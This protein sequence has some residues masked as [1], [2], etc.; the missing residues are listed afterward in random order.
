MY[1]LPCYSHMNFLSP[2]MCTTSQSSCQ[3]LPITNDSSRPLLYEAVAWRAWS[4]VAWSP[5]MMP[6]AITC[7]PKIHSPNKRCSPKSLKMTNSPVFIFIKKIVV[8]AQSSRQSIVW[9]P[10]AKNGDI[11]RLAIYGMELLPFSSMCWSPP[12]CCSPKCP[13]KTTHNSYKS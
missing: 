8:I 1:L 7:S 9:W 3:H 10:I 2:C 11:Y 4:H 12:L 5:K 6:L 13:P